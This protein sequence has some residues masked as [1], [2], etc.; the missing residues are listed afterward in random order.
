MAKSLADSN[1]QKT[2]LQKPVREANPW[3][4]QPGVSRL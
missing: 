3:H 1:L 2:R 4:R